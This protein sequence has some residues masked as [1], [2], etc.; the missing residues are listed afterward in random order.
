MAEV[1]HLTAVSLTVK[2]Q[3][4]EKEEW[5][6]LLSGQKP[7]RLRRRRNPRKMTLARA[8]REA[9]KAGVNVAGATLEPDGRLS[10]QFGEA[11][12]IEA[13]NPWLAE[14]DKGTKQ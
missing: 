3:E 4:S 12:P 10:L 11:V 6:A 14:L 9:R 5:R 1:H 8:L 2:E 7:P 13:D